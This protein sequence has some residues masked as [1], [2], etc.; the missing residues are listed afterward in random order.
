MLK[1]GKIDRI[2]C[3]VI[4]CTMLL[5]AVFTAMAGF[6][7]LESNRQSSLTY[8]SHLF[9]QS[10]VHKIEITMQDWDSFIDTCTNEEYASCTVT[11]DGE[12]QGTAGIRAKG[13][14]SLS[15]V[16][17]YGNDRYSFKIEFDHY[18]DGKTYRG[19]DKL[20]LNNLIQ[21]ATYMK[22]YWSYTFMSKMGVASP[23][24]S[25]TEIYVNGEYWGLYLAVE[26][27]EDAFLERNYGEDSGELYKPDSLSF[28]GGRGNGR[29]FDMQD[30]QEKF[31]STDSSESDPPES[32]AE[33]TQSTSGMPTP[34]SQGGGFDFSS[35]MPSSGSQ[36]NTASDNSADST[37]EGFTPPMQGNSTSDQAAADTSDSSQ[38]AKQFDAESKPDIGSFGNFGGFGGFGMG[39]SDVKL[40]YIDDDPDSYSN[41]FDSAKTKIKEKDKTRLIAALK[42]LSEGDTSAID[43]DSVAMYMA[44]H[45]FLC[46]EDSYTGTMVH[47][48]YLYEDDGVMSMIPWDYNLAFGGFTGGIDAT[49]TV[50]TAIDT[51]VSSGDA[52]ERPMA[53]WITSSKE[54][55]ALYHEKYQQFID[56]VFTSGWFESEY[57]RV[58][59]MIA[60]YVEKET[61]AF[62]TYDEFQTG[63]ATLK[64]FCLKRA[65]S[66]QGQL[67]GSIPSTDSA[68]RGSTALID[69]SEL[70]LSSMGSMNTGNNGGDQKSP[71]GGGSFS[72][73]F[74]G[75]FSTDSI[76]QMPTQGGNTSSGSD[77]FS[78]SFGGS[79]GGNAGQAGDTS[80]SED[81]GTANTQ[82]SNMPQMPAQ[83]GTMPSSDDFSGSFG[84]SSGGKADQAGDAQSSDAVSASDIPASAPTASAAPA[85]ASETRTDASADESKD[86]QKS[87]HGNSKSEHGN[88][89]FSFPDQNHGTQNQAK[90][91]YL[92]ACAVVLILACIIV[93]CFKHRT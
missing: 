34:P 1:S 20:S 23:L 74:D 65:Q 90:W 69:A 18:Q 16:A 78:G 32:G 47:N 64:S 30:F 80:S 17:Q 44:V 27:V 50:N 5:A 70:S 61:H 48:Y 68:Q 92:L 56:E 86:E 19:L 36:A 7:V 89:D 63:A 52:S 43:T 8:T 76:P 39:S 41:I 25:Y 24:C 53:G 29:D 87:N 21:D 58:Y 12:A 88:G 81:A 33:D 77:D 66:V 42:K 51:L 82:P 31:S 93:K 35:F 57:E 75:N 55:L 6:G 28:G 84:G 83:G 62:Y 54:N 91:A 85:P 73:D 11:I 13:N 59:A 2:C 79:S 45:N 9:D 67:D 10:T 49:D 15:S 26:G 71:P 40:Q 22:D 37:P 60:P 46:N 38:S 72:F 14:T 4:V 3:L